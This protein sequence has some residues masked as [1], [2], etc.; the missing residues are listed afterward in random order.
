MEDD[1]LLRLEE[2][3]QRIAYYYNRT[4]E[5]IIGNGIIQY[6]RIGTRGIRVRK[7]DLDAYIASMGH[8]KP[9]K[10]GA[11][12]KLVD[13]RELFKGRHSYYKEETS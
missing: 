11:E 13:K 5:L 8:D 1:R 3:A 7:S 12:R 10:E 4:R 9:E 6:T 2:V